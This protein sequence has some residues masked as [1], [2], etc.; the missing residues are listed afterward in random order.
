MMSGM[1][2]RSLPLGLPEAAPL[3]VDPTRMFEAFI[4]RLEWIGNNQNNNGN[5]SEAPPRL[6]EDRIVES[7][8]HFRPK[9]FD[10]NTEPWQGEQWLEEMESIFDTLGCTEIEKHQLATFQLTYAAVD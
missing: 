3:A 9:K 7:F 8:R 5:N 6:V 10:G 1:P 2:I 4:K